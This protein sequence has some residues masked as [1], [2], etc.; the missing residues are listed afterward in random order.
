MFIWGSGSTE[1]FKARESLRA[2]RRQMLEVGRTVKCK[3]WRGQEHGGGGDLPYL[4][5]NSCS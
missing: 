2:K 3:G 1:E 4:I 5:N